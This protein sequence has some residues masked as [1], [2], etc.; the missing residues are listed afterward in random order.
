MK[1]LKPEEAKSLVDKL[2]PQEG[3][4]IGL[5]DDPMF[6]ETRKDLCT[7]KMSSEGT[8][9]GFDS[10]YLVWK[11]GD[12]VRYKELIGQ[13]EVE[14]SKYYLNINQITEDRDNVIIRISNSIDYNDSSWK[15]EFRER[16]VELGLS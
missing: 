16:K 10:V 11:S 15:R 7:V 2:A 9:P 1:E 3:P 5:V 4:L 12:V 13:F 8:C 14:A 6:P